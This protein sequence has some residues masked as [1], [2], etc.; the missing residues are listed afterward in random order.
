M[1]KCNSHH[2][3]GGW[4]MQ[5]AASGPSSTASVPQ[6]PAQLLHQH[7]YQQE[8]PRLTGDRHQL[9]TPSRE[10]TPKKGQDETWR[11]RE[12]VLLLSVS[13]LP[14]IREMQSPFLSC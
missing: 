6:N 11:R 7:H 13:C 14:A 9:R 1:N 2:A 5:D 8:A 10:E 12:L 3:W 4:V